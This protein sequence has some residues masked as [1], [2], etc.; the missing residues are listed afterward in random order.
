[1]A[2]MKG[3]KEK[4]TIRRCLERV[5]KPPCPII[6]RNPQLKGLEVSR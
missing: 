2:A 3:L 4:S 6:L 1:M 5:G